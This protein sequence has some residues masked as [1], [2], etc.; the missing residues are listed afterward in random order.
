MCG[1]KILHYTSSKCIADTEDCLPTDNMNGTL[2]E[3]IEEGGIKNIKGNFLDDEVRDV[4]AAETNNSAFNS[5]DKRIKMFAIKKS[6]SI[7]VK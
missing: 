4:F 3:C 7:E 2:S 5:N 6:Y 1:W